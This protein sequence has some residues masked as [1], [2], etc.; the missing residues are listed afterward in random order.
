MFRQPEVVVIPNRSLHRSPSKFVDLTT[1]DISEGHMA[2]PPPFRRGHP[3]EGSRRPSQTDEPDNAMA[4][5]LKR[6]K[7]KKEAEHAARRAER[8]EA[9]RVRVQAAAAR[10]TQQQ[11]APPPTAQSEQ[12]MRVVESMDDAILDAEASLQ[13]Q[14]PPSTAWHEKPAPRTTTP[15]P[16]RQPQP[17]D[18]HR[19]PDHVPRVERPR[20][21]D[22]RVRNGTLAPTPRVAER[23]ATMQTTETQE[24]APAKP[25]QTS[26][27]PEWYEGV[28][29]TGNV[30]QI[31]AGRTPDQLRGDDLEAYER[32]LREGTKDQIRAGRKLSE[33]APAERHA[34]NLVNGREGAAT[35][36][37]R[38]GALSP[39]TIK[40]RRVLQ[41]EAETGNPLPMPILPK[42]ASLPTMKAKKGDPLWVY[43]MFLAAWRVG[44][45]IAPLSLEAGLQSRWT[46][47][48]RV[49]ASRRAPKTPPRPDII[50]ALSEALGQPVAFFIDPDYPV[51][52]GYPE[53]PQASHEV[54]D[55]GAVADTK[56]V[57]VHEP[58]RYV[59]VDGVKYLPTY[60]VEDDIPL[61]APPGKTIWG[62][63]VMTVGSSFAI[64][65]NSKGPAAL[66]KEIEKAADDFK[67]NNAHAWKWQFHVGT[68]PGEVRCWRL[69]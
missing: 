10:L 40:A 33:L 62:F 46:L 1:A 16:V 66:V 24:T 37:E 29:K 20:P 51:H 6:A 13:P 38:Y 8:E 61:P 17:E 26:S 39:A 32:V 7:D 34:F 35:R 23:I 22:P 63:G 52:D 54:V 41:G 65:V 14:K 68:L 57:T 30:L 47:R 36:R 58:P 64:P 19:L 28:L 53:M 25:L 4:L 21:S 12:V 55:L 11:T 27:R 69:S 18:S 49:I 2:D 59:M 43:R 60:P 5:A 9:K 44:I 45:G 31:L 50:K 56:A 48:D 67:A 42:S 15:R 3:M